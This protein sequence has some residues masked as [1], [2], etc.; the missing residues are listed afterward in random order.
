MFNYYS[1]TKK[2]KLTC[3]LANKRGGEDVEV[4]L[5]AVMRYKI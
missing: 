4:F 2:T 1:I 3:Y 5:N